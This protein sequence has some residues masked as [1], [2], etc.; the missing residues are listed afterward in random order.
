MPNRDLNGKKID[1]RTL[2][3]GATAIGGAVWALPVIESV[4]MPAAYAGSS[5]RDHATEA[6]LP[7]L[8]ELA[9]ELRHPVT[10]Q[11]MLELRERVL[12]Q[13]VRKLH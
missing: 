13:V 1:R 2:I 8:V 4:A 5:V 7:P 12:D 11:T 6:E 3:K 10:H 9:P